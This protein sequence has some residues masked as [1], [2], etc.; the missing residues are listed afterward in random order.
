MMDV[1]YRIFAFMAHIS[2]SGAGIVCNGVMMKMQEV[3]TKLK[4]R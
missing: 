4:R 1:C 3:D 2:A